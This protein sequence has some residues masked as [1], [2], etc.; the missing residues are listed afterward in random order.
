MADEEAFFVVVG[1]DK[2]GDDVVLA[3]GA[4]IAGFGVEDVNAENFDD[5]E[6]IIIEIPF[7]IGFTEDDKQITRA[8]VY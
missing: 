5:E 1:V 8:G 2:P 7:D 3:A 4:Y 6:A